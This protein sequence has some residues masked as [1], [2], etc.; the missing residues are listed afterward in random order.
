[1]AYFLALSLTVKQRRATEG[2]L[3]KLYHET[4]VAHGVEGYSAE[5][6]RSDVGIGL[7][8][9]LTMWVIA[10]AMLDFSSERA[11]DLLKQLWERLGAALDDHRFTTYLDTLV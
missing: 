11:A 2:S 1:V 9:P 4:L 6:L 3:L 5:D 7:G 10:S 8:S